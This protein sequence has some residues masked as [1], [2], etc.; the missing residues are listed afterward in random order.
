M[1]RTIARPSLCKFLSRS[2][3]S[4]NAN[5]FRVSQVTNSACSSS[6]MQRRHLSST[7]ILRSHTTDEKETAVPFKFNSFYAGSS[8]SNIYGV[9]EGGYVDIDEKD[10][11]KYLPEGLAGEM[12]EE[13]EFSGRKSW[14]IRDTAKLLCRLVD[15]FETAKGI[16]P[17]GT[18]ASTQA[19]PQ[20]Q[21]V[22]LRKAVSL[23]TLTDRPEWPDARLRVHYFGSDLIDPGSF[24]NYKD[25]FKILTRKTPAP[26]T[27]KSGTSTFKAVQGEGSVVESCLEQIKKASKSDVPPSKILLTGPRGVG[28][29]AALNQMVVHARKKGWLCLF[30]PQGWEHVYRGDFVEPIDQVLA[31]GTDDRVPILKNGDDETDEVVDE[32]KVVAHTA[33][34]KD[35]IYDNAFKSAELLRGFWKA[36]S[37]VL[38]DHPIQNKDAMVKYKP[39]LARFKEAWDRALSMPGREKL[40]FQQ[41]R[42]IVEG[43]DNFPEED[44]LDT[45]CLAG[46]DYAKFE[47]KSL[48]DLVRMGVAFRDLSGSVV[49]DLVQ[50]LR[51]VES[52]PVLLAVDQYNTWEA[53]SAYHYGNEHLH[54]WQIAVPHALRFLSK[55]RTETDAWTIK[56]GFCI[57]AVS[58]RHVPGRKEI[59][60]DCKRSIPLVVRVPSYSQVEFLSALAF[61]GSQNVISESITAQELL[62]FRTL[63]GSNPRLARI[64]SHPYFF[65]LSV[66]KGAFEEFVRSSVTKGGTEAYPEDEDED[67]DEGEDEVIS[68]PLAAVVDS[69]EDLVE[70]LTV[71]RQKGK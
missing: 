34:A 4:A 15:Q 30:V 28:K 59:Y 68:D 8:E 65:P 47:L 43:E 23:P 49:L 61:Y 12:S 11:E 7:D 46:F 5:R 69:A 1:L 42:E 51:I 29:S 54:G 36:H 14:M 20:E 60:E 31:A 6:S 2:N 27:N 10:I 52:V 22:G 67:D 33:K 9:Q 57:C 50:E 13:F 17:R 38:K 24:P 45:P 39:Y 44:A 63:A 70:S 62:S 53:P 26:E 56:N 48:G 66:K 58:Q 35:R 3:N 40:S 16:K 32:N 37:E 41:M 64:D 18:N 19:Q 55:R 21:R 71:R 25:K